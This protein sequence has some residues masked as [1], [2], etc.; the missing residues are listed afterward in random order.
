MIVICFVNPHLELQIWS[1]EELRI[2]R[3]NI[4]LLT[5]SIK[6]F[7]SSI[8][9]SPTLIWKVEPI[10]LIRGKKIKKIKTILESLKLLQSFYNKS[11]KQNVDE[12]DCLLSLKNNCLK[13][14]QLII[15]TY[16]RSNAPQ[17]HLSHLA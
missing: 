14:C 3:A 8:K 9:M 12:E 1:D 6:N 11:L 13:Y 17:A 15:L 5:R 10:N 7:S 16:F 4:H 2:D